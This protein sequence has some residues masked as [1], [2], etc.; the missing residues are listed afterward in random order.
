MN[1]ESNPNISNWSADE[2]YN[3]S[4][5]GEG[6]PR[7]I[8]NTWSLGA[9][10]IQLRQSKYDFGF[11]CSD[12]EVAFHIFLHMPG[13]TPSHRLPF[14]IY[15]S[16][17]T[18]IWIKPTLT[19]T[20]RGLRRYTPEQRKCFFTYERPLQSYQIYTM[21]NCATECFTNYLKKKCGCVYFHMPSTIIIYTFDN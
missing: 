18:K 12:E 3:S 21:K 17:V 6:Y 7:R 19:V 5:V 14:Q 11:K 1:V 10:F 2:G 4:V 13:E 9:L 8:A 20:S 16:E 15:P